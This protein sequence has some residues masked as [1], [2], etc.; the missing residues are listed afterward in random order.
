MTIAFIWGTRPEAI[1]IAPV[2]AEL[3]ARGAPVT[4]ICTGQ[5]THLLRGTPAET[6]LATSVALN[7]P[8]EGDV[9]R[10]PSLV[11]PLLA[12]ELSV[13]GARLCVVQGDTMS[14]VAGARAADVIGVDVAHIE[15]GV[16]SGTLEEPW[17]EEGFRREITQ[18]TR[19]HF[20]ATAQAVANLRAD[21]VEREHIF[22][23]GNPVVSALARLGA[24]PKPPE[25]HILLTMHRREWRERVSMRAWYGALCEAC[26]DHPAVE[27]VWPVHPALAP[28]LAEEQ[29]HRA[30]PSTLWLDPPLAYADTIDLLARACG[31]ITDSGGLT[32]EAATLGVPTAIMR[33]VN[34]R[35]EAERE[36]CA[37]RYDPTP[38]NLHIA[39]YALTGGAFPRR[40]SDAYGTP[41]SAANI[42]A[43]LTKFAA[44]KATQ[45]QALS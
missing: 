38:E 19:Y 31:V 4:T 2:V 34:D 18:L 27:V 21:H 25:S 26:E 45:Q 11:R 3:R 5:H 14:A 20:A 33:N 35:P 37:R 8:S 36:G 44:L 9:V 29:K 41:E 7:I 39:M 16:R 6:D 17:P 40:A 10:W 30:R 42:A 24:A 13:A 43:H 23:T 28:A 1:K 22:L 32:E 15:A 12:R